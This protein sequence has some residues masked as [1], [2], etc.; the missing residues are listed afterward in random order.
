MPIRNFNFV[1]NT[2]SIYSINKT[3]LIINNKASNSIKLKIFFLL[4]TNTFL[5]QKILMFYL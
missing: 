3:Y 4:K 2:F 1:K 5:D